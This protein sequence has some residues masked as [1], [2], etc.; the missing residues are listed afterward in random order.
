MVVLCVQMS[1]LVLV[2][3]TNP[4]LVALLFAYMYPK[5]EH[6]SKQKGTY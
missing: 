3:D 6:I 2:S 4:I 1:S 5:P